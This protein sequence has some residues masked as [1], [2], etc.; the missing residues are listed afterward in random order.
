[1][2]VPRIARLEVIR[3]LSKDDRR[4]GILMFEAEGGLC[5]DYSSGHW[6]ALAWI[7]MWDIGAD[8]GQKV[9]VFCE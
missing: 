2:I 9:Q 8:Q 7:S 5:T 1:V 4:L 3:P 6:C